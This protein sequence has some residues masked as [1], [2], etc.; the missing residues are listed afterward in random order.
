MSALKSSLLNPMS[1]FLQFMFIAIFPFCGSYILDSLHTL[2]FFCWK[3]VILGNV[4][5]MDSDSLPSY[6]G[7]FLLLFAC[8]LFNYLVRVFGW[9]LF[10]LLV[11]PLLSLLREHNLGH[12]HSHHRMTVV[13]ALS[14]S[15]ISIFSCLL[16]LILHAVVSFH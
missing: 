7:I 2:Q 8:F 13:L 6:R 15:L 3:P 9:S 12:A 1:R 4:V 10:P 16:H 11:K 5:S 14:L